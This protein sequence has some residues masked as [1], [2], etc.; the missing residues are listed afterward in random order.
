MPAAPVPS[1]P[2]AI[3]VPTVELITAGYVAVMRECTRQEA[4]PNK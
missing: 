2:G 1:P 4:L 3:Q